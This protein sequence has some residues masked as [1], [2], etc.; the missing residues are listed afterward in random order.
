MNNRHLKQWLWRRDSGSFSQQNAQLPSSETPQTS[1][2][3]FSLTAFNVFQ[4]TSGLSHGCCFSSEQPTGCIHN[5]VFQWGDPRKPH[6]RACGCGGVGLLW[7]RSK[8]RFLLKHKKVFLL[9]IA[10]FTSVLMIFSEFTGMARPHANKTSAM[11]CLEITSKGQTPRSKR[12]P[13]KGNRNR[14]QGSFYAA[15]QIWLVFMVSS[16]HFISY[17]H[18]S[19]LNTNHINQ[20]SYCYLLFCS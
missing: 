15:W 12:Q 8:K 17:S 16:W 2:H 9:N 5:Q 10:W 3:C 18:L 11:S 14:Y 7:V 13:T 20:N 1:L 6:L 19:W 4:Q